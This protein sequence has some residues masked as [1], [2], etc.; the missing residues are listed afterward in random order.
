[1]RKDAENALLH[2]L[3]GVQQNSFR[4]FQRLKAEITHLAARV[5]KLENMQA[6]QVEAMHVAAKQFEEASQ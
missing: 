1:M 4:L 5:A 2:E 6:K 3:D